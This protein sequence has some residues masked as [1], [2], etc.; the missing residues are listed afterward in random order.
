[1]NAQRACDRCGRPLPD[2]ATARRRFCSD[3]CRVYAAR[4]VSVTAPAL[5]ASPEHE[6]PVPEPAPPS[7]PT[8][9]ASAAPRCEN[10]PLAAIAEGIPTPV[11]E[12]GPARAY[13]E[14]RDGGHGVA[15]GLSGGRV[16]QPVGPVFPRPRRALDLAA[17]LN[18][19]ITPA[20]PAA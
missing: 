3:T 18:D 4:G 20:A 17:L 19:R 6:T 9:T 5:W 15:F 2:T 1:M 7:E 10:R 14:C 8:P 13:V 12:Y 16:N 11:D